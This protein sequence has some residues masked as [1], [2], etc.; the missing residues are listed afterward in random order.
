MRAR[1]LLLI[2]STVV[3]AG[4]KPDWDTLRNQIESTLRVSP[5]A[6]PLNYVVYGKIP[7][8]SGVDAD[9]V[10]YSTEYSLRV[11]AIIYHPSGATI[12]QHPGVVIVN[13]HGGDKSSWYSFWAGILYARAG[14]VV[15]TYDPI[16]EFERNENQASGTRE[17]DTQIGPDEMARRLSGLMI[18]DVMQ[19]VNYLA[20]RPDVDPKRIAVLGFSMG[21]FVS[22]VACAVD[23]SVHACILAGGGDLDGP[24]G[25]W[26]KSKPMCQG[27]PYRSLSFL[28]D[29]PAVIFALNVHRGATLVINGT[30]DKVVDIPNHGRAFFDDLR[31]RTIALTGNSKLIFDDEFVEGGTHAPYFLSKQAAL[32][33]NEKLKFPGWNKKDIESMPETKIAD[34][35]TKNG[36]SS[37]EFRDP[38]VY[39]GFLALGSDIPAVP[40]DKLFAIPPSVW[41]SRKAEFVYQSWVDRAGDAIAR[42]HN[43]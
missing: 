41:A 37:A 7:I 1:F 25:Y 8:G 3:F 15:L 4:P 19:A 43:Q 9:R 32:W 20:S 27:I 38:Q 39:G 18:T 34:W 29:R 33:L 16:G 40:R 12:T 11:P 21:S 17:H 22:S 5:E 30:A 35:V 42:P 36:V 10:A 13:G 6:I 2:P 14:T 23:K 24:G 26:D 28:G 31:K